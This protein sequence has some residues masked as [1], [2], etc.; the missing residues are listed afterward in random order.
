[1][2]NPYAATLY[3]GPDA[4][5]TAATRWV[6]GDVYVVDTTGVLWARVAGAWYEV[7]LWHRPARL[8]R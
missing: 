8:S 7:P 2:T 1:M 6:D 3:T 4:K 5:R